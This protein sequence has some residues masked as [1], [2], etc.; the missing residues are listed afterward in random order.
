M[1]YFFFNRY[2]DE[3]QVPLD[4]GSY[5]VTTR[6]QGYRIRPFVSQQISPTRHWIH[7]VTENSLIRQDQFFTVNTDLL[8]MNNTL[9]RAIE[10]NIT[11]PLKR[12]LILKRGSLLYAPLAEDESLTGIICI[13]HDVKVAYF[14]CTAWG[15]DY[16]EIWSCLSRVAERDEIV[17]LYNNNNNDDN[18][19]RPRADN[20]YRIL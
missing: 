13:C 19:F 12:E 14:D 4:D 17:S 5:G 3:Y 15:D 10:R 7:T 9:L 11:P 8:N 2:V 18:D 20:I 16:R 6:R 1:I